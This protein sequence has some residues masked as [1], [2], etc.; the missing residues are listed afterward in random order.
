MR[1]GSGN[2]KRYHL[3]NTLLYS[4]SNPR[5]ASKLN[6]T[7]ITQTPHESMPAIIGGQGGGEPG[8]RIEKVNCRAISISSSS[9]SIHM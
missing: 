9:S 1:Q 7:T 3:N 4:P 8:S 2:T 5:R 6:T